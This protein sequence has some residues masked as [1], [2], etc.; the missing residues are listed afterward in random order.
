MTGEVA[1][2][3]ARGRGCSGPWRSLVVEGGDGGG[4]ADGEDEEEGRGH[5]AEE[6]QE[7]LVLPHRRPH[8]HAAEDLRGRTMV[9]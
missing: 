9:L 2:A 3:L 7:K 5:G 4:G 1:S 6:V 8:R